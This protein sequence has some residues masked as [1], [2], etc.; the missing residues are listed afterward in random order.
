MRRRQ[1]EPADACINICRNARCGDGHLRGDVQEG[2]KFEAC[3]DGNG[4]N[5]DQC[6]NQCEPSLC[7]NGQVDD[8]EDC[9]DGN[10]NN[11]DACRNVC[12]NARCGD[13]VRRLDIKRVTQARVTTAT[14][15]T[16]ICA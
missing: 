13:G 6:N 11:A 8:G 9:D 16:P 7:G 1:P 14:K 2:Q 15:S 10:Q 4:E 5:N 3:D 12:E